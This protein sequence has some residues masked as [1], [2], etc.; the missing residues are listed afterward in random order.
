MPLPQNLSRT[1]TQAMS[2][3]ITTLI[4]AT[5]AEAPTVSVRAD[6]ESGVVTAAQ[7]PDGPPSADC[8]ATA[9][10]GNSTI[11][12]TY[13][14]AKPSPRPVLARGLLRRV[15]LSTPTG[16]GVLSPDPV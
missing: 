5:S 6:Q 12:L 16:S 3:P 7:K 13:S 10:S 15:R 14:T 4:S 2:V 1:K 9:A 11:R 8:Q